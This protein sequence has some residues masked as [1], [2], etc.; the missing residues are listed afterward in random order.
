MITVTS[1]AL[2]M[3]GSLVADLAIARGAKPAGAKSGAMY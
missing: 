2:A 3:R 1:D